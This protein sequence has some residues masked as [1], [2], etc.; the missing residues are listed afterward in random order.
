MINPGMMSSGQGEWETP[1][2]F[3]NYCNYKYGPFVLDA[4]ASEANHKC[5]EYFDIDDNALLH[6]WYGI[7]WMNPPYGNEI[8]KFIGKAYGEVM[9]GHARRVVC[10]LPARTDTKWF[11]WYC[12]KGLVIFLKGRLR[13]GGAE[14]SAPFPSMLTIFDNRTDISQFST[15]YCTTLD[16]RSY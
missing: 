6:D 4:A 7:V 3:F 2:D 14:N 16:W 5:E 8:G 1:Q 15:V 10:L 9:N 11:H 12:T 13:F